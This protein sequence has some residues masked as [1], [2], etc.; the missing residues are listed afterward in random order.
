[1]ARQVDAVTR[2]DIDV[3]RFDDLSFDSRHGRVGVT[4]FLPS[5]RQIGLFGDPEVVCPY[6]AGW[7]EGLGAAQTACEAIVRSSHAMA[8][9]IEY[10]RRRLSVAQILDFRTEVYGLVLRQLRER[11]TY[12]QAT[13][14]AVGYSRGT[15]PA[16]LAAVE[17]AD[18]VG[19][20]LLVAPTWFSAQI[21][22]HELASR[23]IAEGA[24]AM[25]RAGWLDRLNL[26]SASMRLAQEMIAHPLELSNDITAISRESAADLDEVL[27]A[28]L[29]VAVVGGRQDELCEIEGIRGVI[30]KVR[31]RD[32]VDYREVDSDHFSYFV[33]PQPQRVVATLI[34]GLGGWAET[35]ADVG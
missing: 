15:A 22:P 18:V 1:M 20:L 16:R 26:M 25:A 13:L 32:R 4:I 6:S 8:V 30:A 12:D 14:V 29:R 3:V 21:T 28:G 24:G 31:E 7:G 34:Q 27:D 10:P 17:H 19:G 33:K 9:A 23:G 2:D 35:A 11:T 5:I